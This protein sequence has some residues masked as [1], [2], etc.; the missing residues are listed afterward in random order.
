MARSPLTAAGVLLAALAVAAALLERDPRWQRLREVARARSVPGAAVGSTRFARALGSLGLLHAIPRGR[1]PDTPAASL[2]PIPARRGST[3]DQLALG[4]P[5]GNHLLTSYRLDGA[6]LAKRAPVVSLLMPPDDLKEIQSATFL[7]GRESE[8]AAYVG[9]FENGGLTLGNGAGVRIHGGRSRDR[10]S[11]L[12]YRLTARRRHGAP[13]FSPAPFPGTPGLRPELPGAQ[14]P[15]SRQPDPK[16]L[17]L[18]ANRGVDR[19]GHMWHFSSPVAMDIARRVGVPT[20]RSRPVALYLNGGYEGVYELSDYLGRELIEARYGIEELVLVRTKR[21]RHEGDRTRVREGP[22]QPYEELLERIRNLENGLSQDRAGDWVDLENLY[23]WVVSVSFLD[24]RDAFQGALVRDLANP[25]ARWFWIAWD[26][27]IS[28]GVSRNLPQS[29][30]QN[31]LA[32]MFRTNRRD[33]RRWL[34][35]WLMK[36]AEQR[37]RFATLAVDALN[38]RIDAD[39]LEQRLDFYRG[40]AELFGLEDRVFLDELA[41]YLR[42]RPGAY[43]EH[44]GSSFEL[45]PSHRVRVTGPPGSWLEIDGY[46]TELPWQG[47][48]FDGMTVRLAGPPGTVLS[49]NGAPRALE[50]NPLEIAVRAGQQV[51]LLPAG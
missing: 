34:F 22:E 9:F 26:L 37:R 49:I 45:G 20:P 21:N 31:S 13:T 35:Q 5:R 17:V 36:S 38:H 6:E 23:R 48:Y 14:R 18:R 4:R 27:E 50:G 46:A 15:H 28:F 2:G 41:D 42:N 10:R 7:R 11:W 3:P 1:R 39:F 47:E 43:R 32:Y 19:H 33:P 16:R 12:S 30:R 40:Q 8:R 25:S 44:L 24:T 51:A 29:W